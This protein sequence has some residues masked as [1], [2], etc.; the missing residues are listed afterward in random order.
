MTLSL[1]ELDRRFLVTP[2]LLYFF[3]GCVFY[4]LTNFRL[5][6]CEDYLGMT[7]SE[8][9][10]VSGVISL[11][12][13]LLAPVWSGLADF[14]HIH[15]LVLAFLAI[16]TALSFE[17]LI[18]WP[19]NYWYAM[20]ILG[21]FGAFVGGIF[22]LTDYQISRLLIDKFG[23]SKALYGRQRM[24]GTVSYGLTP[25]LV[26]F[27]IDLIGLR[28]FFFLFPIF[29]LIFVVLLHLFGFRDQNARSP[30]EAHTSVTGAKDDPSSSP[31]L[32]PLKSGE[33]VTSEG[34][35]LTTWLKFGFLLIS[36]FVTG[37]GRQL[38]QAFL[39]RHLKSTMGMSGGLN[40][41]TVFAST[42]LS[43]I[44]M[45]MSARLLAT[46]GEHLMLFLGMVAMGI[47]LGAYEYLPASPDWIPAVYVIELLNGVAFSFTHLAG[48]KIASDL[49]PRQMEATA[50]ALY[51]GFYMHLPL[52]VIAPLGGYL[53]PR[54]G[55]IALFGWASRITL[56]YSLILLLKLVITRK[57]RD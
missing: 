11:T 16:G 42:I 55:A 15:R 27:L 19:T 41:L 25:I 37:C 40:G 57:V 52:I 28:V 36:V 56:G 13:F 2:K 43:I 29:A 32:T 1:A 18:L 6:F 4:T 50:Q 39:L 26:G 49:A 53:Y 14:L 34:G 44:F 20:T 9:G 48:F 33:Q 3:A 30:N 7:I 35:N 12:G 54:L 22:P 21:V 5:E 45:F 31:S 38:L 10:A 23:L 46:F 8:A 47:R 51:T 24:M 17:L